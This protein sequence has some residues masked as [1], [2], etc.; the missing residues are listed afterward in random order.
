MSATP[1]DQYVT[2]EIRV[3]SIVLKV[4]KWH[5]GY[6]NSSFLPNNRGFHSFFGQYTHVSNCRLI[7]A[8]CIGFLDTI[9]FPSR[10]SLCVIGRTDQSP[11]RWFG[12]SFGRSVGWSVGRSVGQSVGRLVSRL[13]GQSVR[14]SIGRSVD[15]SIDRSV[16]WLVRLQVGQLVCQSIAQSVSRWLVSK[17]VGY[18][19]SNANIG[20]CHQE[21]ISYNFFARFSFCILSWT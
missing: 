18:H 11:S 19:F 1:L 2:S 15:R 20:E 5:L 14:Q 17:S 12:W 4:G 3:L 8:I 9:T 16:N 10:W 21:R 13:V 7:S 6:C